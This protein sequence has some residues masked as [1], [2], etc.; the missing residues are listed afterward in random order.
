MNHEKVN[1]LLSK[2]P[3]ICGTIGILGCLVA[4]GTNLAGIILVERHDPISETISKL[5]IG[6]YAWVQDLGLDFF[7]V[8]LFATAVGLY[9][10]QLGKLKWKIG[11]ALLV[12][13]GIDV[14]LIAE[15]N[16]YANR[17]GVGASIHIQCVYALGLLFALSTLI[18]AFGLRKLGRKWYRFSLGT[19]IF[20]TVMGPIFFFVPTSWDGAF[21]RFV[22]LIMVTWV[23]TISWL[24]IRRGRGQ[25]AR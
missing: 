1:Q 8:A 25:F 16:Q 21:E 24:L 10:W 15:H 22:A 3:V 4:V 20:W 7:A 12:L 6:K 23:A 17:A 9:R 19:S 2:L 5:A 18:L 14:I 11:T 13:L